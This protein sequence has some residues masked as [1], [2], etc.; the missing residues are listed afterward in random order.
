L[1]I[2]MSLSHSSLS[3]SSLYH[4]WNM[5]IFCSKAMVMGDVFL[6]SLEPQ[7]PQYCLVVGLWACKYKTGFC[8]CIP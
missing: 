4:A 6:L 3:R 1:K 2:F 8:H 7:G 5:Q